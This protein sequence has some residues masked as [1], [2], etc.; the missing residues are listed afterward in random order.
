MEAC[1][2]LAA[3]RH[4]VRAQNV[5]MRPTI[6]V[7]NVILAVNH[8]GVTIWGLSLAPLDIFSTARTPD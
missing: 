8:H 3:Y 5:L 1:L 6:A 2:G 7:Y 4:H